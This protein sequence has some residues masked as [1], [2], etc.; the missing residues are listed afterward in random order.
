MQTRPELGEQESGAVKEGP[1]AQALG[2]R[3]QRAE[4]SRQ[5]PG[6]PKIHQGGFTAGHASN[7]GGRGRRSALMPSS[8]SRRV[9]ELH[10]MDVFIGV[11]QVRLALTEVRPVPPVLSSVLCSGKGGLAT[12]C[13][14]FF[15][16]AWPSNIL[17]WFHMRNMKLSTSQ[18]KPRQ[19]NSAISFRGIQTIPNSSG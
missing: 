3:E 4:L 11:E 12:S 13:R 6:C 16:L 8:S 7:R 19:V 10:H 18:C 5:A 17:R 2:P 1:K 14:C 9:Y 15:F